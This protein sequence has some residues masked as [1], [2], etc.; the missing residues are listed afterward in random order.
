VPRTPDPK[1]DDAILEAALS[2]LSRKG[3]AATTMEEVAKLAGV[4]KPAVYRRYRDKAALVAAV[5]ARQLPEMVVP[6]LGDTRAELW[7]AQR[8]LPA[9]APGYVR[10]IGG[11]IAEE[12]RHPELIEAF[13]G[14]ILLPRR[15]VVCAAIE[16]GK[17]RGEVRAD[18][19]PVAA[20]DALAGP[21]LARVFAGIDTGPN[22]REHAFEI[23][24]QTIRA[25]EEQ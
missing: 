11:L 2:L 16:R 8:G 1:L 19:D 17:E 22:W 7:Q 14:E 23:W 12:D 25:K 5:I 3:F 10:L 6:D 24:W 15:A 20:V 21:L 4:G 13:R 18:V 9:D